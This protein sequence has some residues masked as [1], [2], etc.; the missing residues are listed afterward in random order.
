[1]N[2]KFPVIDADIHPMLNG[3]HVMDALSEPWRSRWH[4]GQ[5]GAGHGYMNPSGGANRAD[6]V[7]PDGKGIAHDPQLLAKHFFEENGLEYGILNPAELS[8]GLLP[9]V[10]YTAAIASARNDVLIEHWLPVD[11]RFRGSLVVSAQDPE[12]AAREIHRVGDHPGIVQVLMPSAARFPYGQKFY[13]P[14]YE[15]AQAHGLPM[16]IHPG[17]ESA[18]VSGP[19]TPAGYATSYFEWHSGL[20][21]NYIAH[22]ISLLLEGVFVKFPNLKFVLVEGG[23]CW[24]P[25]LLWRLD[26]NWKGL[27]IET[28]WLERPPS[29]YA[30][31]HIYLTTQPI[32]EPDNPAHL[33][34]MLEMLPADKMLMFSTDFPHWDGDTPDF[35]ARH[36][37]K[38]L[39][40]R[41]MSETARELYKLP[42]KVEA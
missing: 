39:L 17:T 27:R 14:I 21:M 2:R 40:P 22:L 1:M 6:A 12:A 23:V 24:V 18:G 3:S 35:T 36:L 4:K 37:P 26:K 34:T 28:P 20:V 29:H 13:W 38:E 8:F 19:S 31:E 15:A 11:E 25:P 5:R 41:V 32:E 16:A 30:H 9:N 7:T 42:A 33:K 10:D